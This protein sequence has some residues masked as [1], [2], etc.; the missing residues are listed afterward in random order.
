[1]NYSIV[2]PECDGS[3]VIVECA[4]DGTHGCSH[5]FD[6]DYLCEFCDGHGEVA[7]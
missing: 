3:G 2:C 7:A 4:N 5:T 1:M 6:R